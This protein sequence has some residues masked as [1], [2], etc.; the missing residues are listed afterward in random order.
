ME[1]LRIIF[2][3]IMVCVVVVYI[4]YLAKNNEQSST[5]ENDKTAAKE[6]ENDEGSNYMSAGMSIGMCLGMAV[7]IALD[8]NLA[9][10][11]S[12][13]MMLG[14]VIGLNIKKYFFTLQLL[15]ERIMITYSEECYKGM[16]IAEFYIN[17]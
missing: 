3:L 6:N 7:S 17:V 4:I 10:G 12:I 15:H 16:M 1:I 11:L 5:K 9:I 14:M 8:E 2:P 13:G